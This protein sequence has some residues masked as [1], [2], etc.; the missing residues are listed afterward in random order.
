MRYRVMKPVSGAINAQPW[1]EVGEY[2][3]LPGETGAAM[4]EAGVL[5]PAAK[6]KT[7]KVEKRPTARRGE[8]RKE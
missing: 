1:P 4:V 6:R 5:E 3:D 8:T 2:I 7:E